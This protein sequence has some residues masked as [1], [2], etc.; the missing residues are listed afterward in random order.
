M[1]LSRFLS[2]AFL[3]TLPAALPVQV[4][5]QSADNRNAQANRAQI[6]AALAEAEKIVA[7]PGYSGRIKSAKRQEIALL[8]SRLEDGDLQPGDQVSLAVQGEDK[9]TGTFVV[10]PLRVLSLPGVADISVRGVLRSELQGYMTAQIS[11]YIKDPQVHALPTIRLSVLGG[12]GKPGFYQIPA[13]VL[14]GDAIMVAGLANS[15]DPANT[16]VQRAGVEIM[17]KEAFRQSMIDGKSLDQLN[18]RAGDEILVGG[19]RVPPGASRGGVFL[20]TVLPVVGAVASLGYLAARI[21][22]F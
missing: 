2:I 10:D 9:L 5:G 1:S 3:V 14:A 20:T 4:S 12:V 18:L 22:G 8:K 16:V 13:G 11:K 21:L 19:W 6:E 15:V 7:S 17:S